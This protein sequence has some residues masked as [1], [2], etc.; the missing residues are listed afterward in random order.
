MSVIR[1]PIIGVIGPNHALCSREIYDFGLL[2]GRR[3]VDDGFFIACGGMYGVMESV[4]RGAHNSPMYVTGSTIGFIPSIDRNTANP[5]CDIV[6]PTG[7][8]LARNILLVNTSDLLIAVGGGAG[9]L[10]EISYAWQTGKTVL[11]CTQ[12]SGWSADLAGKSLDDRMQQLLIPVNSL[13][14]IRNELKKYFS[15][16]SEEQAGK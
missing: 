9:T 10:S 8:G 1:K 2:L 3:L 5:F 11:C 6:I 7:M 16:S 15:L 12:F 13:E 14:Q 4:C